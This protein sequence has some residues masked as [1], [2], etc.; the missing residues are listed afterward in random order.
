M[1]HEVQSTSAPRTFGL[2]HMQVIM[3]ISREQLGYQLT[4]LSQPGSLLS[5][6]L[7]ACLSSD[8]GEAIYSV[9]FLV[10]LYQFT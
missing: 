5:E 8:D 4:P 7:A 1:L 3:T 6:E 10:L 9:S 2:P